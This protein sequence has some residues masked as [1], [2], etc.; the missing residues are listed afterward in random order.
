MLK[1]GSWET[2]KAFPV[3]LMTNMPLVYGGAGPRILGILQGAFLYS[4]K[5]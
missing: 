1:K 4:P 5:C 3:V 2:Q